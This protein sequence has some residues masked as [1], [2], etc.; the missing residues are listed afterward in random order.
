MDS[1]GIGDVCS[2]D[3]DGDGKKNPLGL[4]DDT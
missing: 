3:I 4:V 1:N 2:D